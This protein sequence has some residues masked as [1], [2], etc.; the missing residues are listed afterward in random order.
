MSKIISE[1]NPTI[2]IIGNEDIPENGAFEVTIDNKLIFSKLQTN[3]FPTYI[4]IETWLD[5]I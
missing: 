4:E 5:N 1:I 3:N 2:K